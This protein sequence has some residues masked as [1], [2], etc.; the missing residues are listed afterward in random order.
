MDKI[1]IT[2]VGSGP[3]A[4]KKQLKGILKPSGLRSESLV[5]TRDPAKPPPIRVKSRKVRVSIG[6]GR[7]RKTLKRKLAKLTDAQVRGLVESNGLLKSKSMPP[8]L[9][10]EMVEGGVLSGFI[11]LK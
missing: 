11:S 7:Y 1:T 5:K 8:E 4:T 2:R 6:T 10:R 9:M 3:R